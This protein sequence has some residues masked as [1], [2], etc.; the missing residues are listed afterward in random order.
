MV[1]A[2]KIIFFNST[3]NKIL[4]PRLIG[5]FDNASITTISTVCYYHATYQF[6]SES[7]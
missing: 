4:A 6:Q 3:D 1:W 2:K 7:T 5:S